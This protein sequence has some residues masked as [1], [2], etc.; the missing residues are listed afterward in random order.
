MR[1]RQATP[2]IKR[3]SCFPLL[4]QRLQPTFAISVCDINEPGRMAARFLRGTHQSFR[5]RVPPPANHPAHRM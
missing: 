1:V 2:S 4:L 5:S 3:E